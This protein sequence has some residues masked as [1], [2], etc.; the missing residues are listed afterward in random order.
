MA[1]EMADAAEVARW[2]EGIAG[3]P[4]CIAGRF[5]RAEPRRR[6]LEYLRGL[7]SS[8]GRKNGGQWAEPAGDATPD[9]VQRRLSTDRWDADQVRADLRD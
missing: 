7:L 6:A 4:E 9:G 5:R 1:V 8:V 2:G 3:V